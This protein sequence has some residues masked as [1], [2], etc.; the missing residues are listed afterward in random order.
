MYVAIPFTL[1]L[2][3]FNICQF[4]RKKKKYRGKPGSRSSSKESEKKAEPVKPEEEEEEEEDDDEE[5][6]DLSKYKLDVRTW[7]LRWGNKMQPALT[8]QVWGQ[9]G[10]FP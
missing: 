7:S 5:E 2:L 8:E 6:G 10:S 1:I 9:Y 4:G 3:D